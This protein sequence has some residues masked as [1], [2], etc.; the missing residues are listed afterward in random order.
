MQFLTVVI[1]L[2]R[3]QQKDVLETPMAWDGMMG[4]MGAPRALVNRLLMATL[5]SSLTNYEYAVET[6]YNVAICP[7]GYAD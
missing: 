3:S 7:I 4:R 6:G 5:I 2:F 1:K